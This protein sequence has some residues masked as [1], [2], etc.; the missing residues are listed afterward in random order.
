[1]DKLKSDKKLRI[2]L[3]LDPTAPDIHLGH[4]IV[5]RR[6]RD[7]QDAGHQVILIIGDYTAQIGDPSGRSAT[8]PHLSK[9]DIEN[10]AKTYAD[11]AFRILDPEQTELTYNS[12][13][14]DM[15]AIDLFELCRTTT[16]AQILERNDFANRFE[17]QTPISMLELLYP[18]VQGYDSVATKADVELGGQDQTFNLLL[19][20][21]IQRHYEQPEQVALTLPIL[22]GLDGTK[23]M[24]KS[25]GNYI[26]LNDSAQDMF[27]KTMSIPDHVMPEW[28]NLLFET[29]PDDI[30][31]VQQK[32][33]L[34]RSI[35]EQFHG[36]GS[37]VQ[38]EQDF[39]A[40]FKEKKLP[41][42][43]PD[44]KLPNSD[45]IHLPEIISSAFGV[46]RA[47]ARRD[48][49]NGAIRVKGEKLDSSFDI[50][51]SVIS[52]QVLQRGKLSF[53]RLQD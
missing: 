14:L 22:T 24:S 48:L 5:L 13:W 21:D 50:E 36:E 12:E 25:L 32:R 46:S 38:A 1:L 45:T 47:Q 53:V 27:G 40:V 11:Q 31:F 16:V 20:R 39:N 34:A 7:F 29:T 43:I 18:L 8:R 19:A 49:Q 9:E 15:K 44:Y 26:A 35:V 3:G 23:K 28:Y 17:S 37:G 10:A 52:G 33:K 41:T 42:D 30:S 6:L 51:K 4:T 2:K